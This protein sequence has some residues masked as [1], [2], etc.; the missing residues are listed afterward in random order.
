MK[1]G[2][3]QVTVFPSSKIKDVLEK[4]NKNGLNGVFVVN[5]R[6]TLLGVITDSDIRRGLLKSESIL[7]K[8]AYSIAKKNYFSIPF[9]KR[10]FKKKNITSFKQNI[11]THS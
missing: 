5:K 10:K 8:N 6:N 4:I 1:I 3:K 9:S 2:L 11:N 7:S